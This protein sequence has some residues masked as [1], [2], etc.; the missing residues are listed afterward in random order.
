MLLELGLER[1]GME[2]EGVRNMEK[3]SRTVSV[4]TNLV[5]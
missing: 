1:R 2:G 3:K 5:K 4:G